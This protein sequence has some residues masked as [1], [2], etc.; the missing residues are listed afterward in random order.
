M[1][2]YHYGVKGMKWGVRKALKNSP[3]SKK[4]KTK[5]QQIK[6]IQTTRKVA[7]AAKLGSYALNAIGKHQY[8][9]Y[10]S[11]AT[12][13]QVSFVKGAVYTSM[14]LNAIGNVA[15]TSEYIQRYNYGRNY[16]KTNK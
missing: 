5:E 3:R 15:Y 2:L 7:R 8:T 1:E 10:A 9:K 11:N 4:P 16:W 14:A 12:P 13:R 6:S